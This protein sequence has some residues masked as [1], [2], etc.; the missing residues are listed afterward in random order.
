MFKVWSTR[1]ELMSVQ[2]IYTPT[3]GKKGKL[4]SLKFVESTIGKGIGGNIDEV[5]KKCGNIEVFQR[6]LLNY[7]TN[8]KRKS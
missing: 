8:L 7:N 4:M 1:I 3:K 5:H 6:V 2:R